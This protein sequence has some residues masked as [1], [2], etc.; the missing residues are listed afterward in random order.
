MKLMRQMPDIRSDPDKFLLQTGD[1]CLRFRIGR[2]LIFHRAQPKS[3]GSDLLQNAV[4]QLSGNAYPLRLLRFDQLFV[5][6]ADLALVALQHGLAPL[7]SA[8]AKLING[9]EHRRKREQAQR[10][11][12]VRLPV[13]RRNREVQRRALL[14]PHPAVVAGDHAEAVLTWRE[15]VVKSLAAI[16][17]ILPVEIQPFELV[18][19]T[20]LLRSHKTQGCVINLQIA[21]QRRQPRVGGGCIAGQVLPVALAIG[22]DLL[23]VHRRRKLVEGKVTRID[24][25][26]AV[27]GCEPQFPIRGLG[28]TG[29]VTTIG[30]MNP[31][32]VGTVE[33]RDL[34]RPLRIGGPRVQ[35]GPGN[36]HQAAGRVQPHRMLVIFHRPVNRIAGQ[37]VLAGE[38]G[39][40]TVVHSAEAALGCGP[41]RT[42][43]FELEACD[44]ALA[45][46]VGGCVRSADLTVLEI[47]HTT[48]KKSKPKTALQRIREQRPR[49]VL[50]S[51]FGPGNLFDYIAPKQ[52]KKTVILI[53]DPKIPGTVPGDGMYHS[54][55]QSTYRSKPAIL[56]AGNPTMCG[57]PNPTAIVL[58]ERLDSIIGQST[59]FTVNRN[60]PVIPSV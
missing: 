23:D 30:R 34:D 16:S 47:R 21:Y 6:R 53:A 9:P 28:D 50:V 37:S 58:K 22:D 33:D 1:A 54:T 55:G 27:E 60:L 32:S 41:E 12:P 14:V 59:S 5:E 38:R 42:V 36:A 3:K 11:E 39:H 18:A 48:L 8:D 52:M 13:G 46:T 10:A 25:A 7:Q 56:K 57:H 45:Q 40:M 15:I 2:H 44:T 43:P 20:Y 19:K 29:A 24:D 35:L 4:V 26:D 51:Q 17:C 31:D 49:V